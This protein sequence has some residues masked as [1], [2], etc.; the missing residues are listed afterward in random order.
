MTQR[1]TLDY[2]LRYEYSAPWTEVNNKLS[3]FVPGAG[4][5]T[6]NVVRLGWPVSPRP[7]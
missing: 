2:G 4:L 6:P 3:N 5:V 7:Q 1:L